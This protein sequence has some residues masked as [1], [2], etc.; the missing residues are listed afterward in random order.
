M[1]ATEKQI[2]QWVAELKELDESI[3]ILVA[4]RK[5]LRDRITAETFPELDEGVNRVT[6][7]GLEIVAT[8][9]IKRDI[10]EA[11]FRS[12]KFAQS[13]RTA[14]ISAD[15]LVRFKAELQLRAYRK[16]TAQQM[17]LFDNC[18]VIKPGYTKLEIL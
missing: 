2:R 3:E 5:A 15:E 14:R 8:H 12:P 13:L 1:S 6:A 18:L 17:R 4:Q 11:V 7:P 9:T 16:L 10:D